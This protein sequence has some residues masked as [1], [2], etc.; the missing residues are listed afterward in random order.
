ME[1]GNR[2]R[3][4]RHTAGLTQERVAF[5]ADIDYKRYQRVE[6]GEVNVTLRTLVRIAD[7]IGA[8]LWKDI[9]GAIEDDAIAQPSPLDVQE[10]RKMAEMP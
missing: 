1:L 9:M 10:R 7:A 3:T 5:L 2:I 8:D 4:A 6:A